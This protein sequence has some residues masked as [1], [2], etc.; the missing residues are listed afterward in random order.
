MN[1]QTPLTLTCPSLNFTFQEFEVPESLK[2]LGG[3]QMH[4]RH[5]FPGGRQVIQT[6]GAFPHDEIKW[7]GII[8]GVGAFQRAVLLDSI[9]QGGQQCALSY[10]LWKYVGIVSAL[11]IDVRNQSWIPYSIDFTPAQDQSQ[12]QSSVANPSPEASLSTLSSGLALQVQLY[13]DSNG[14]NPTILASLPQITGL[15]SNLAA[16]VNAVGGTLIDVAP[17]FLAA[18]VSITTSLI[19]AL[20]PTGAVPAIDAGPNLVAGLVATDAAMSDLLWE[21]QTVY[22][23]QQFA[24]LLSLPPTTVRILTVTDPCL[25]VL[26]SQLYGDPAQY[27]TLQQANPG[28]PLFAT[29]VFNLVAPAL[30]TVAP[31]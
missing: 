19:N 25:L 28:V 26:A 5:R 9:R 16:A 1:E 29:G 31:G 30:P 8:Q 11:D 3:T 21:Q 15:L 23:L 13:T 7:A 14:S 17:S 24:Y 22:L 18:Q 20:A 6:F 12:G 10:G 4:A 2:S 27:P